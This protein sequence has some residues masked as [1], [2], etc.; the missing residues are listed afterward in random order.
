MANKDGVPALNWDMWLCIPLPAL[1]ALGTNCPSWLK[2]IL[3]AVFFWNGVNNCSLSCCMFSSTWK[4]K[5][6]S[7]IDGRFLCTLWNLE[8]LI[9]LKLYVVLAKSFI[10]IYLKLTLVE[11]SGKQ[12]LFLL[13]DDWSRAVFCF[14]AP[15]SETESCFGLEVLLTPRLLLLTLTFFGVAAF[16]GLLWDYCCM[17]TLGIWISIEASVPIW[18]ISVTLILP[19]GKDPEA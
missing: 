11:I 6:L 2:L 18:A 19:W 10:L 3:F 4:L 7:C 8:L 1:S 15:I 5:L 14:W 16:G 17:L 12:L 9:V 13:K